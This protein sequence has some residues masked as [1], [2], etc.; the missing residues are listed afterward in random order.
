MDIDLSTLN[1]DTLNP[2]ALGILLSI[3]LGLGLAAA[4]GFRIFVPMLLV[5]G[6]SLS[7]HLE[8]SSGFAWIGTYPALIAFG[9]ATALEVGAYF[10]PW[11]DNFLDSIGAPAAAIAGTVVAA[12]TIVGL[13]PMMKWTLAAI[14]GGGAAGVVH[15]GMAMIRGGS[16]M[17]TGGLANPL[18]STVE[19]GGSFVLAFL[20]I[21]VPF[22]GL[23]AVVLVAY[24]CSRLLRRWR[25]RSEPVGHLGP[26]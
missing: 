23:L 6:A 1:P 11:V 13:D 8:L 9:I 24:V 20:A 21:V 7:G 18:V 4:S 12:S 5:S 19:A 2:E 14:A 26:A 16:S 17:T 22:A 3:S 10:I 15:S 25:R